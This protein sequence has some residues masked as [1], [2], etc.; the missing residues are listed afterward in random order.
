MNTLFAAP[1]SRLNSSKQWI[2][3]NRSV[4][5]DGFHPV[6]MTTEG[7]PYEDHSDHDE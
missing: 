2:P 5:Y 1:S 4:V 7:G 6:S 3:M